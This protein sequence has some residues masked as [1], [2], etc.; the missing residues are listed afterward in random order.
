MSELA[1]ERRLLSLGVVGALREEEFG[2]E[3]RLSLNAMGEM[4]C[5]CCDVEK[6]LSNGRF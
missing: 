6:E 1:V 4:A 2:I 3:C 5:S